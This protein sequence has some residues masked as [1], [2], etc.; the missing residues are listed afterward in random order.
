MCSRRLIA[1]TNYDTWVVAG[2]INTK[3]KNAKVLSHGHVRTT[4]RADHVIP[5]YEY[6]DSQVPPFYGVLRKSDFALLYFADSLLSRNNPFVT[7]ID[8]G[9]VAV[10]AKS[11]CKTMGWGNT[12]QI[13]KNRVVQETGKPS[14]LMWGWE[15]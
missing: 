2:D 5:H 13:W 11:V 7:T 1:S 4:R 8:I 10:P 9:A 3:R 15:G 14:Y 6:N 12:K